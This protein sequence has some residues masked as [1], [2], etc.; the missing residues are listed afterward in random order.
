M[1]FI[2]IAPP[3]NQKSAGS[4]VLYELADEIRCLGYRATR[5]ILAQNKDGLFF[6]SI[7]ETNFIPLETDTLEQLFDPINSVIIHGEIL[8]HKYFDKFNVARYYLNKIGALINIGVPRKGEYK[9]AWN[10]NFVNDPDFILRRPVIKKPTKEVLQLDQP[11]WIDLTY[12]GKGKLYDASF[13]RLPGTL[14][15]TRNWPDDV[16]EY[17]L[18]LSKSRFLFTYDVQTAVIEEAIFYGVIPVLLTCMPMRSMD[19]LRK[20][21]SKE[22]LECC[23]VF[24]DFEKIINDNS[25]NFF[26]QFYQN[27]QRFITCLDQQS[28]NYQGQLN[29]LIRSIQLRFDPMAFNP[30]EY[31]NSGSSISS[32]N[33]LS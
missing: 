17:L 5:I 26:T 30:K 23:L 25:N 27:R 21:Y 31:V 28:I 15:L 22:L 6:I 32:T 1:E 3:K 29:D 13:C 4:M 33:D 2:V 18:L 8:H 10:E 14:E 7:D 11:R 19:E 12:V 20:I 24:E 16:D 9:I